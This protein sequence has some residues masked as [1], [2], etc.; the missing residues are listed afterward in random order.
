MEIIYNNNSISKINYLYLN[1]Y[2]NT[3]KNI[4]IY[5][6][7]I[8]FNKT[9]IKNIKYIYYNNNL[10]LVKKVLYTEKPRNNDIFNFDIDKF[11]RFTKS[12]TLDL[13]IRLDINCLKLNDLSKNRI[14][15]ILS[16]K[17][18]N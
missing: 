18:I 16:L 6:N 4:I 9:N 10:F 17:G 15:K 8:E 7:P 2:N 14:L 11:C 13:I 1:N 12:P 5:L 3:F